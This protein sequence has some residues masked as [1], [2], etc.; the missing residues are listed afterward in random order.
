MAKNY[1][2][3]PTAMY[4]QSDALREVKDMSANLVTGKFEKEY[5]EPVKKSRVC[6]I[7]LATAF[8][9]LAL[10]LAILT[11]AREVQL[12]RLRSE[13]DQLTVNLIAVTANVK[14]LN[15]KLSSNKLFNDFRTMDD[16]V[17]L[18]LSLPL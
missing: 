6:V 1:S 5:R 4:T 18:T 17:S 10:C 14:S 16:T 2:P 11:M 12:A 3:L 8:G 15:Q 13:V 7:A 9:A